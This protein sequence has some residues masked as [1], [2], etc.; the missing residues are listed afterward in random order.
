LATPPAPH[1]A[2]P[3]QVP[4]NSTPPQPSGTNPHSARTWAQVV[5]RQQWTGGAVGTP[6]TTVKSCPVQTS[7]ARQ[8][9]WPVQTSPA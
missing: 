9:N 7:P 2:L 4:Q 8:K 6:P 1:P 5:G 3:E